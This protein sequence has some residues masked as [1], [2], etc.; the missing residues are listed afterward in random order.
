MESAQSEMVVV[1]DQ[2][3]IRQVLTNLIGNAIRYS[4]A[5]TLIR[6]T[7]ST[8]YAD[9]LSAQ[10]EAFAN[11][12]SISSRSRPDDEQLALIAVEDQGAGISEEQLSRLFNRYARG[13]RYGEG[14]GLGLYLSREFVVRHSGVIWAESVVG[15]GSIF[16][17]ALPL[18][19]SLDNVL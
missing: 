8:E 10:H 19:P 13:E 1:C 7:L 4:S 14:L 16:Y 3:R 12:W 2:L 6:V 5:N 11:V 18:N 15:E 17:V 9:K